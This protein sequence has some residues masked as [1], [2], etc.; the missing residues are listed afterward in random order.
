MYKIMFSLLLLVSTINIQPNDKE[1]DKTTDKDSKK[2]SESDNST[3][4][5]DDDFLTKG[6]SDKQFLFN[7]VL[8]GEINIIQRW[9]SLGGDANIE[10]HDEELAV[11]AIRFAKP[12]T[13]Q[14]LNPIADLLIDSGANLKACDCDGF[15]PLSKAALNNNFYLVIKIIKK[16]PSTFFYSDFDEQNEGD[17]AIEN[18][19]DQK[20][21][22][23]LN[24]V[25]S[26]LQQ[27]KDITALVEKTLKEIEIG[28]SQASDKTENFKLEIDVTKLT[29]DDKASII[30]C[31]YF[32]TLYARC[33]YETPRGVE[34]N[35]YESYKQA[36]EL[37]KD[38]GV[39][40]AISSLMS[41]WK[42][43][44]L[45]DFA[46]KVCDQINDKEKKEKFER[47]LNRIS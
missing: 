1:K 30:N 14:L 5:S 25:K 29:D 22:D 19:N 44:V 18:T 26:L 2:S 34:D 42:C 10:S 13:F 8:K 45:I 31:V 4:L 32:F 35:F 20:I 47:N 17:R 39:Q 43:N 7:A 28:S 12:D 15:S 11:T 3:E 24:A 40:Q 46:K 36:F 37:I 16:D 21:K 6:S 9:L 38:H 41:E 23:F 27:K 33:S